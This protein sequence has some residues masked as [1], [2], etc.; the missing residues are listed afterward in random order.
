MPAPKT[1]STTSAAP[2]PAA[3][4]APE[5]KPAV[6]ERE[7]P[8]ASTVPTAT[9]SVTS[10][11]TADKTAPAAET[12]AALQK[13]INTLRVSLEE[14]RKSYTD[15]KQEYEGLEKERDFYFEKLR[16]IEIMLQ[17]LEDKGQGNELTAAIFKILY[18]T[19][20]GFEPQAEEAVD[21][22]EGDGVA[23]E[24]EPVEETY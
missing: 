7:V 21:G 18:A 13:E 5:V 9:A 2:A 23:T 17:D 3:V 12:D 24:A 8:R 15:L 19:A 20:D 1:K 16:D 4:V 6:Q 14:S 10:T 11:S 22:A